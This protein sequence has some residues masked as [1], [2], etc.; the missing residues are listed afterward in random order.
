MERRAN[1][2]T[3]LIVL[4]LAA[5]TLAYVAGYFVLSHRFVTGAVVVRWFRVP[6]M[7]KVYRPAAMLESTV[8]RRQVFVSYPA[9]P[10]TP[11]PDFLK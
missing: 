11:P 9:V 6:I 10:G 1:T 3:V 8:I 4:A 7:A 2:S 5:V